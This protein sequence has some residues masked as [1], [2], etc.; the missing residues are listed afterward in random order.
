M[1]L[2]ADE[3]ICGF[4][5]TGAD[6]GSILYGMEPDLV[7]VAKGL[8]SGYMPLSAAI[9]GQ[10]VYNVMEEA[11]DRVGA[12]SHGYTYSGHPIAAAAANAVLDIFEKEELTNRAKTVGSH[13]QKRLKERFAQLEIVG[14]VR[15]VGLLGAIEFVADRQTKR[16]FDPQIKVGARI[17]KAARDRGLIARAMPHGDILGFAPPLIVSEPEIDEMIDLAYRATKQVMDELAK[18]SQTT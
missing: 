11:A 1:L 13:F 6:F 15:G 7:T 17:S 16:R 3:V 10:R 12:F 4:G 5:R 18:E 14:E 8:T 2:I 9:V